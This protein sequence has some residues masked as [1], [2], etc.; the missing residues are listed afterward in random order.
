MSGRLLGSRDKMVS[1]IDMAPAIMEFTC[2]GGR[3]KNQIYINIITITP[4]SVRKERN[5]ELKWRITGD[6]RRVSL[7]GDT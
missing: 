1:E 3:I 7:R 2:W 4:I 6:S 5:H